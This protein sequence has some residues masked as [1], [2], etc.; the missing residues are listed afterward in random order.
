MRRSNA[1]AFINMKSHD[2][3]KH[4]HTYMYSLDMSRVLSVVPDEMVEEA[5]GEVPYMSPVLQYHHL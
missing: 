5:A 3:F 1:L 4:C 2:A